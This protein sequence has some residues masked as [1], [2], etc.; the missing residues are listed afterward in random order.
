MAENLRNFQLSFGQYLRDPDAVKL[1]AGINPSRVKIYENLLFNNVKG[2]IDTC[3]PVCKKMMGEATWQELARAFFRDWRAKSPYFHEIPNE[4]L[5]YLQAYE[6]LDQ[7]PPWFLELAHYEWVEL[8]VDVAEDKIESRKDQHCVKQGHAVESEASLTPLIV[9]NPAMQNVS[10]S[11]PVHKISAEY[12]P[13][14]PEAAFLVVYRN[15]DLQ[16]QF[17]EVNPATSVMLSIIEQQKDGIKRDNLVEAMHEVMP[18]FEKTQLQTFI[19]QIVD[20][21]IS[22]QILREI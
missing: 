16:V 3:F 5:H 8:A 4:F 1:P 13:S 9:C 6:K 20:Q 12:I 7:L 17:S 18:D 22:Q 10:Y 2:F 14:A 19:Y 15:C 21:L 11:W